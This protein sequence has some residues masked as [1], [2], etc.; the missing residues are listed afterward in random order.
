MKNKYTDLEM[1]ELLA[2]KKQIVSSCKKCDGYGYIEK[3]E[4]EACT[5]MQLFKY[6]KDLFYSKIPKDY[7]LITQSNIKIKNKYKL[8]LEDYIKHLNNAIQKGLGV[9]F[10]GPQ[11]G[12]GKTSSACIIGKEAIQNGYDVFYVIAQNIIDDRFSEEHQIEERIKQS[13]LLIIDELDKIIMKS[14]SNIPK[15]LENLLRII[16]PNKKSVIICTNFEEKEIEERFEITSLIN[17]YM[18]F[19]PMVGKDFSKKLKRKWMDRLHDEEIN[20]KNKILISE[21]ENHHNSQG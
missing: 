17:R 9:V 5:C 13:D 4:V 12:I 16:L 15:Q 14:E 1:K 19:I 11:R 20:Y 3:A 2:I 8:F 18:E 7:W 10:S 21:A 6:V